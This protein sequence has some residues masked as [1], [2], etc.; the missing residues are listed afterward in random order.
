MLKYKDIILDTF[1]E[2]KAGLINVDMETGKKI[3]GIKKIDENS[4]KINGYT[5]YRAE[6]DKFVFISTGDK[7]Y[8]L[9]KIDESEKDFAATAAD[10][11]IQEVISPMPGSV[12]KVLVNNN[13]KV[14]EGQPLI[15][16]EAMKMETTIYAAIIGKVDDISVEDGEQID[17]DKIL[18]KVVK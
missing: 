5:Y 15:I 16:I 6:D 7:Y 17:S 2:H 10:L 9:Q 3:N 12:V 11:G 18:M 1:V 14:E 13:D 4:Y 8:K